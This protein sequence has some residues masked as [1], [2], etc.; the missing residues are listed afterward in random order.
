MNNGNREHELEQLATCFAET[1]DSKGVYIIDEFSVKRLIKDFLIKLNFA[2]ISQELPRVNISLTDFVEKLLVKID[3]E[4]Q[5]KVYLVSALIN[6]FEC[7]CFE[8]GHKNAISFDSF[9]NYVLQNYKNSY[10]LSYKLKTH[11][12]SKLQSMN[13]QPMSDLE[14]LNFHSPV[15][16]EESRTKYVNLDVMS[17]KT[18]AKTFKTPVK[19]C[20]YESE[21]RLFVIVLES[22]S[23]IYLFD[24]QCNFVKNIIPNVVVKFK[25]VNIFSVAYSSSRKKVS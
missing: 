11:K 1:K 6:L 10:P 16:I 17:L 20:H 23:S 2:Q 22:I 3:V 15:V 8:F 24:D 13:H 25:E 9:T 18:N 5:H 7:I 14:T 12:N 21:D 19:I 4:Q